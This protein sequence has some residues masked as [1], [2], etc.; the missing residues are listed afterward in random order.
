MFEFNARYELNNICIRAIKNRKSHK[1][2]SVLLKIHFNDTRLVVSYVVRICT[3][4]CFKFLF[5]RCIRK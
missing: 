5:I 3:V 4:Y 1:A 2:S